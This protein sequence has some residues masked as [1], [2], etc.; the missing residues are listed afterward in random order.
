MLHNLTKS[1]Q[2]GN[3][4]LFGRIRINTHWY[5]LEFGF[6]NF[7]EEMSILSLPL[8][9]VN[10]LNTGINKEMWWVSSLKEIFKSWIKN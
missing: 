6:F 3:P 9:G 8:E 5:R 4:N 2:V 7:Y 10:S 1:D